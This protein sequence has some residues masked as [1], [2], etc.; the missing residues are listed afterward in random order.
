MENRH[1]SY[2]AWDSGYFCVHLGCRKSV[3]KKRWEYKNKEMEILDR[4]IDK[5]NESEARERKWNWR[6]RELADNDRWKRSIRRLYQ[7]SKKA[8][9]RTRAKNVSSDIF[10]SPTIPLDIWHW[11]CVRVQKTSLR[12]LYVIKQETHRLH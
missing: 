1:L 6:I 2:A 8:S 12:T 9:S 3:R 4:K 11:C 10:L 5:K 7:M